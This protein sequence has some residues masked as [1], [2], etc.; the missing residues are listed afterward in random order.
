MKSP[1][2]LFLLLMVVGLVW[3]DPVGAQDR[4]HSGS[5]KEVSGVIVDEEGNPAVGAS[6]FVAEREG[7]GTMADGQGRFK[8][9]VAQGSI[10]TVSYVGYTDQSIK[11][12]KDTRDWFVQLVPDENFLE[13]AIVVGYGVQ[14]KESIVGAVS[15][16]SSEQ[17]SNTGTQNLASALSGK[18][19]GLLMTTETGAPGQD[20]AAILL[21]GLSSFKASSPLVMVDG[22]ERSMSDLN[23]AEV[24]SISILK[25]AS[26]TAV[27]GAKGANGVIIVT[28]KT[29]SEGRAK[30]HVRADM[31]VKT[32]LLIPEHVGS[33]K[34]LEMANVAM[35]NDRSFSALYPQSEI[36]RYITGENPYR[37]PDNDWYQLM[38]RKMAPAFNASFDISGG[39]KKVKYYAIA[40]Y[41]HDGSL[42]KQVNFNG[43]VKF[44]SDRINFRLNLTANLTRSTELNVKFGGSVT[45][46]NQPTGETNGGIFNTMYM[47]TGA[48]YPAFWPEDIY[49]TYPDPNYPDAHGIRLADNA[50]QNYKNPYIFILNSQWRQTSTY[51]LFSDLVLNQKL[52]FITKGLSA[53]AT[54][55]LTSAYSRESQNGSQTYPYW[56]I[57]WNRYDLGVAD[58]WN[59]SRSDVTSVFVDPPLSVTEDN[60]AKN[61]SFLHYIEGALNYARKFGQHDVTGMFVYNQRQLNEGVASPHRNQSFV[62]RVTYNYGNKYLFE[63]NL[64]VTGSE[65]FAPK[66]RYGVFPSVAVG[67]MISQEKFWKRAIPWWNTMKVRFSW[68]LVGS[69]NATSGFLYYTTYNL[70]NYSVYGKHYA[71]GAAANEGARWETADKKDWGFEMGF[72]KDRLSVNVDLFDEYRY[73]ILM[74][75]VITPLV[76][77]QFKD[78]NYGAMKKHGMD[79][80]ILW[81][82]SLT[83]GWHYSVGLLVGLN[84]NRI[85]K[86]ADIP[87]N[88]EYKKYAG[89][90]SMSQRSGSTLIDDNYFQTIDE[91]HG[92][93]AYTSSWNNLVPGVYKFMD[94]KPDGILSDQD[95][96]VIPGSSY[97]PCSYSINLSFG[98]KGFI[99][100]TVGTGTIGKYIRYTRGYIIPFLSGDLTVH[101][102]QLDYW[103]PSN[104]DSAY[105]A[106]TF[107]DQMY[108]WAGG[109]SNYPGYDLSLK[110]YTWRKSDYFNLSELYLGYKF[111]GKKLRQRLGIDSLTISLTCN[112]LF[113]ITALG[114]GNPQLHNTATSY[115]PLVRTTKLGLNLNF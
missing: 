37:Y 71:E 20:N 45:I 109:S 21:R 98:Y 36:N 24:Q 110:D 99:L 10:L 77:T 114:E 80:D 52:D 16:V 100:R 28:T 46:N 54:V 18:V 49:S 5:L 50:G 65:Q 23:P 105:P 75:P 74:P 92:Y 32:P 94:Y 68:G 66:Y 12:T 93:P 57:D 39:N 11:V 30:M 42:L 115:Y 70:V 97:P 82:E 96:H 88:P 19:S 17:L 104:R 29:G 84:E 113:I 31:G 86:Y 95:L 60:S 40:S 101:K 4:P 102:S 53:K 8:I 73:D 78:A 62:G 72:L 35:K 33:V 48:K 64:G 14:K 7:V 69:D 89:T 15:S 34:T 22:V 79:I 25:D 44:T 103:S 27:F 38:M 13:D 59:S 63:G 3:T 26:A 56:S 51:R 6:V 1:I 9:A 76:G 67:Y 41:Y 81:R 90:P 61:F 87:Y 91:I 85:V 106:L 47:A 111:D 2:Q 112:N 107:N 58:I 108:S 83:S 55:S 43:P